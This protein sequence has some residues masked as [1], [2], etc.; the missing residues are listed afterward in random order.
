MLCVISYNLF[1][2]FIH[3]TTV[4]LNKVDPT[5]HS[6]L[7]VLRLFAQERLYYEIRDNRLFLELYIVLY[8]TI[9]ILTLSI[10][11]ILIIYLNTAS[12]QCPTPGRVQNGFFQPATGPF[13]CNSQVTYQCNSDYRLI[14]QPR[15]TCQTNQQWSALPCIC[16]REKGK[17]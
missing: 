3:D 15:Q 2:C 16:V 5:S 8:F 7:L 10:N 1:H 6:K 13:Y 4:F 14:G 12:C 17:F 11:E 9:V